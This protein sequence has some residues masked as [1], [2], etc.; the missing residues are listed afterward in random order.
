MLTRKGFTSILVADGKDGLEM[1][2]KLHPAVITLN[3]MMPHM[4]GWQLLAA[5]KLDPDT[6][7]IPV[8]LVTLGEDRTQGYAL[9]VSE[10]LI[11]PIE[12]QHLVSL[13]RKYQCY[14][15]SGKILVVDD[16]PVNR[17]ILSRTVV[18]AGYDIAEAGNGLEAL[19]YLEANDASLVLL[20]LMMSAMDGLQFLQTLRTHDQWKRLPVVVVNAKELTA[21][22][23]TQLSDSVQSILQKGSY[24][25][26]RLL[27]DIDDL[28]SLQLPRQNSCNPTGGCND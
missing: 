7:D 10:Y 22:E 26:E 3:L 21:E 15:N 5:L 18:A 23:R 8:I 28:I 1:A 13:L 9:G 20:D 27:H 14:V 6:Q 19:T 16:D 4:D 25:R 2:H 12:R 17:D 11:K 24:E